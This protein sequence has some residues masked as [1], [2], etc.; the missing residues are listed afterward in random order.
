MA[1]LQYRSIS[2]RTVDALTAERE[3]IFWDRNLSGFGVRVYPSGAKVYIV[4]TRGPRGSKRITLG[5]HGV[6][7]PDQA[8]RLAVA[9]VARIKD[10]DDPELM[11]EPEE[12][13]EDR[14]VAELAERYLREHVEVRCKPTTVKH[15]R[16]A[17]DKHIVP[18]LGDMQITAITA[19]LVADLHYSLRAR[20]YTANLVIDTL[21][22]V[23]KQAVAWS[24]APEGFNPC[25][26][27]PRYREKRRERFLTDVEIRRLGR[28]LEELQAE[29]RLPVHAAA[30][31]RLL[32]LTGC[33]RN[34][35]VG[36]QWDDVDF[37]AGELS[38]R[39]S[40]TGP[41]LVCLSPEALDVLG[42]I[43][44][45]HGNQWVIAGHK[46]D[47]PMSSLSNHWRR[48]RSRADLIDVR[49]HDLRHTFASRA[50]ALG[51][52][53]PVIAKLLGHSQ[54]KSTAR[55]VHL[56]QDSVREAANRV[57][58]VIE[59]DILPADLGKV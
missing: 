3:T 48:V 16:L 54:V 6:I 39:D 40:K 43:P 56:A 33:R 27:V 31:I 19:A 45:V 26:N 51:E 46:P 18:A 50:L 8:R 57:A 17:I 29:G 30:A 53:L 25:R 28:A 35:I 20:P 14:R 7:A 5:R 49:L 37:E 21:S 38:L 41:R 34:E 11:P 44:R 15:Y 55:Y 9:E 2:R 4:Q 52:S 1:K 42:A 58:A 59:A 23:I 12:P 10:G 32:A 36:L 22:Q 47:Q 13:P 24:L